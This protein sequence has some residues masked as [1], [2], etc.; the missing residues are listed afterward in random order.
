MKANVDDHCEELLHA[1]GI[2]WEF[3]SLI[4]RSAIPQ[5]FTYRNGPITLWEKCNSVSERKVVVEGHSVSFCI[6]SSKNYVKK[7]FTMTV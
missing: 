5:K 7:L 1:I 2:D 3:G 6:R 4:K